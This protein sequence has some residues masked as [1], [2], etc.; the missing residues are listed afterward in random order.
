M[1]MWLSQGGLS[2]LWMRPECRAISHEFNIGGGIF[3]WT[4]RGGC[5]GVNASNRAGV[6]CGHGYK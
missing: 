5:I 4:D 6:D 2:R 1:K 3:A